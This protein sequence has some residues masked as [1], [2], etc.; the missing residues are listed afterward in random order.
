MIYAYRV[1]YIYIYRYI[2]QQSKRIN[3]FNNKHGPNSLMCRLTLRMRNFYRI[4]HTPRVTQALEEIQ[5]S[6]D[7]R[8]IIYVLIIQYVFMIQFIYNIMFCKENP[9]ITCVM[10]KQYCVYGVFEDG[11]TIQKRI[12]SIFD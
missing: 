3:D 5:I 2:P 12:A 4:A 7:Y 9:F 11:S 10:H 6:D 1:Y 8:M